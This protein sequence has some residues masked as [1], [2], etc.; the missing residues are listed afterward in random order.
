MKAGRMGKGEGGGEE[1]ERGERER[2]RERG[3]ERERAGDLSLSPFS[4]FSGIRGKI[5]YSQPNLS[6]VCNLS[7]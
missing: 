6:F 2:G 3:R 1:E 7:S 4:A 5:G